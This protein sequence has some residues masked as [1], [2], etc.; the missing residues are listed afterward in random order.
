M[1]GHPKVAVMVAKKVE[2][3]VESMVSRRVQYL[4]EKMDY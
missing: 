3:L 2:I 1:V 4:V